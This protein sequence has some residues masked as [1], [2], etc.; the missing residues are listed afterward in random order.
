MITVSAGVGGRRHLGGAVLVSRTSSVVV[1]SATSLIVHS[2]VQPLWVT[3]TIWPT[4][5]SNEIKSLSF[6]KKY[7][8]IKTI[9]FF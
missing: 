5:V 6:L 7:L 4:T 2:V 1:D 8:W 9:T 3:S